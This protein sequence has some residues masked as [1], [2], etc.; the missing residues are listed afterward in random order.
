MKKQ[1]GVNLNDIDLEVQKEV[2]S[3]TREEEEETVYK[4]RI[5][6]L[7]NNI[8]ERETQENKYE[9]PIIL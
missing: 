1:L 6:D 7:K 4:N 9:K 8:E 5:H 3:K 2:E